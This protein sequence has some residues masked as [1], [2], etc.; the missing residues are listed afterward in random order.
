MVGVLG[1]SHYNPVSIPTSGGKIHSWYNADVFFILGVG[2][3]DPF[4]KLIIN[5]KK[6][7]YGSKSKF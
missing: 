1:L 4:L 3:A 6:T 2:L 5:H 7:R